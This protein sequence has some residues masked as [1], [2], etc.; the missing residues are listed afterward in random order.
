MSIDEVFARAVQLH[1]SGRIPEAEAAYRRAAELNPNHPLAHFALG[2]ALKAQGR[3]EEAV[4]AYQ[5]AV[6]VN[7]TMVEAY[8]V[9]GNLLIGLRRPQEAAEVCRRALAVRPDYAD[10]YNTLGS[11]LLDMGRVEEGMNAYRHALSLKPAHAEAAANLG[12]VLTVLGRRPEAAA[13]FAQAIAAKPDHP[14]FHSRLGNLL[15]D[16]GRAKEAEAEHRLALALRPN[17]AEY[18]SNLGIALAQLGRPHDALESCRK[19]VELNPQYAGGQ[20]NLGNALRDLGRAEE[21]VEAY[22]AALALKPDFNQ[23]W[24]NLGNA[25]MNMARLDESLEAYRKAMQLNP[26][27]PLLHSNVIFT[28]NFHPSFD[29]AAILREAREWNHGHAQPLK[30]LLRPHQNNRDQGRR[31]RVGYV[32]PDFR[33][34]VVGWNLLPLL[35]CHDHT[36]LEVFCYSSVAH[37]DA[38]TEQIRACADQWRDV[39]GQSD[40]ALVQRI[41]EDEIDILVDLSLHTASNRLRVFAMEPAPVQITYLGYCGTSGVDAMHYRFSDPHL[42]PPEIDLSTYSEQTIRLPE[43]YWCYA[44]GGM[45]PDVSPPPAQRN[46]FVTFGC[47]NQFAKASAAAVE[48]WCEILLRV[49][50]SR[51][52]IHAPPG[53]HLETI[54]SRL[55]KHGIAPDRVEFVG[56]QSWDKYIATY[57]RIDIGLDPFP[58]N[59]GI[60]TCDTLW[61]GVPVVTLSGRTAVGRGGR[62]I[63]SNIGLPEL[64]A[65]DPAGYVHLAV[66]LAQDLPRLVELRLT[67]RDRLIA[68]PLM[69]GPRFAR[70]VEAAYLSAW[71][72]WCG[73]S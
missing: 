30:H 25:L 13:A 70:N 68:S 27:D 15:G 56:A 60:T 14:E 53:K 47:M 37:A 12:S 65:H 22:R 50:Q 61:M 51:L 18:H 3:L 73:R 9:L 24:N 64:I 49:P 67:M 20:N 21:A 7:P 32:S 6:A 19:A 62:S 28:M 71:Q 54:G 45:T 10:G 46:G 33:K 35:R 8:D 36:Q 31:L 40:E 39:I 63:L 52:L 69:D 41:R 72:R 48:L 2:Q 5:R 58:Y 1:Q 17:V 11:A 38:M 23:A 57:H 4:A 43:T 16:M 34:H 55:A 44:P 26:R 42:D 29:S 66:Q 59:G